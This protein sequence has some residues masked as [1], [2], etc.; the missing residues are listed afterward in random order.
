M[1]NFRIHPYDFDEA[2]VSKIYEKDPILTN[3]P[4]L[5]LISDKHNLY[6]GETANVQ[7]RALQHLNNADK[8][9]LKYFK[10][11]YHPELNKSATLHIE[12]KLIGHLSG[13]GTFNILNRNLGQSQL[14]NYYEKDKYERIYLELWS[15]LE[16]TFNFN[17]SIKQIEQT[18][19]FKY[20][21][22]KNLD[23]SQLAVVEKVIESLRDNVPNKTFLVKGGAGTGKSVVAIFL[24]KLLIDLGR[25]ESENIISEYDLI[26]GE[27]NSL[28]SA[29]NNI[30][31]KKLKVGF[32]IPMT[33][34]RNTVENV[35]KHFKNGLE[36]SIVMGPNDIFKT[37]EIFDVLVV[38]EAHRLKRDKSL[39][40]D[41]GKFREINRT[42][43]DGQNRDQLDWIIRKSKIQVLFYDKSQ[44]I[45]PSDITHSTFEELS[46]K[47]TTSNLELK[48]Q[49]RVKA[50]E[51]FINYIDSLFS[52]TNPNP[53]PSFGNY[54]IRI[55]DDIKDFRT[56]M[57]KMNEI[58]NL[59]RIVAGFSWPWKTKNK[60]YKNTFDFKINDVEFTWN[61]LFGKKGWIESPNSVHEV[62]SIHTT[63]G[64]DLNY[65][66][67]IIGKDLY[68]N[69]LTKKI[70]INSKE[71]YDKGSSKGLKNDYET[72]KEYIFNSYKTMMKRGIL[73]LYLFIID[74]GLKKYLKT[75]FKNQ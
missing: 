75:F 64:F 20:S 18:N 73:G 5:Y 45:R 7:Y 25:V 74:D 62:G 43:F 67:L 9:K 68:F 2:N 41:I 23:S 26:D 35:F 12:S 19:T 54:E 46:K 32:I 22:Y 49:F 24:I 17:K 14:H 21:P 36:N 60:D 65:V 15:L 6:I 69:P 57:F 13:L 50:G 29:L 37:K 72:L 66:G 61:K 48:T 70:E 40:A 59:S 1:S 53:I 47:K 71:F 31:I 33:N 63:Q 27:N 44:S 51:Q 34:F 38:D 3:W 16:G 30:S 52:N 4:V 8:S 10:I 42:H 58:H 56:E 28:I 11:I 55:F 39:G